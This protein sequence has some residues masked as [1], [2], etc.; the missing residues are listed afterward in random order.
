M[1]VKCEHLSNIEDTDGS[2]DY[3]VMFKV[4][5]STMTKIR[6]WKDLGTWRKITVDDGSGRHVSNHKYRCI[7]IVSEYGHAIVTLRKKR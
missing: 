3:M 5:T 2:T 1:I 6:E 4:P 7:R